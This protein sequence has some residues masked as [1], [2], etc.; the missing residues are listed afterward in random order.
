MVATPIQSLNEFVRIEE[1]EGG[2][3]VRFAT[4]SKLTRS[5]SEKPE[6]KMQVNYEI[7]NIFHIEIFVEKKDKG[8]E[9]VFE[10]AAE[11]SRQVEQRL[12]MFEGKSKKLLEQLENEPYPYPNHVR[13][14]KDLI[15]KLLVSKNEEMFETMV[16]KT[17]PKGEII[18]EVTLEKDSVATAS[19]QNIQGA[20]E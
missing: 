13:C 16:D 19:H 1:S 8:L 20:I 5:V 11:K 18:K 17:I 15:K 3:T 10:Y 4:P 7:E 6:F 9:K 2:Q 14:L 12:K